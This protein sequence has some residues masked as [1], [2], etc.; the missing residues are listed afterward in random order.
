M[1]PAFALK[2]A[3]S[4]GFT[5]WPFPKYP[6]SPPAFPLGHWEYILASFAKSSP[7][8]SFCMICFAS[9]S[10][11]TKMWDALTRTIMYYNF[12]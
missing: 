9:D 11:F 5:I 7:A 1:S 12:P 4:N 2:H 6:R 8:A 10:V 3:V